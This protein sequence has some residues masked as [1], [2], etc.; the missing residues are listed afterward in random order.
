MRNVPPAFFSFRHQQRIQF[1]LTACVL[2]LA[3]GLSSEALFDR[4]DIMT[5]EHRLK[6]AYGLVSLHLAKL[7]SQVRFYAAL[8]GGVE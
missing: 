4:P 5:A 7:A 3:T 2:V 8:G 6:G 1:T